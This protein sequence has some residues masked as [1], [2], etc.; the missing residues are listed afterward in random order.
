MKFVG[1]V[2]E[3]TN[4]ETSQGKEITAAKAYQKDDDQIGRIEAHVVAHPHG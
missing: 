4:R 2:A 1:A 3:V